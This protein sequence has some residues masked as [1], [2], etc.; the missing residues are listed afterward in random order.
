MHKNFFF[1]TYKYNKMMLNM[2]FC[3][4]LEIMHI[5]YYCNAQIIRFKAKT[6]FF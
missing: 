5:V 3:N 4:S 6:I 2:R 1:C